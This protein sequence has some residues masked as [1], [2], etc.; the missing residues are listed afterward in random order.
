MF[1]GKF[2]SART[3]VV[4][5]LAALTFALAG[6]SAPAA[7][8][9]N[10]SLKGVF[11]YTHGR[12]GGASSVNLVVGQ[13]NLDGQG[14]VTSG[15][16]TWETNDGTVSFGITTGTYSVSKNCIGTLTLKDEDQSPS[17]SHFRIYLNASNNT[18]QI[19]QIDQNWNQPGFAVAQGT[20]TCGLSGKKQVFTTNLYG[21]AGGQPADTV[22]QVTLDGKG[23][24][25]GTE[26]F[27]NNG[28]VSNLAVTGSYTEITNCTG[29]WRI[30]P[31]NGTM[32]IFN[33]VVVNSGNELLLIQTDN[34]TFN[35]GSAQE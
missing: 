22:G 3:A 21:L 7:T 9:S 1:K 19:I 32:S 4:M 6:G 11:G 13:L 17:P 14:K 15:S 29:T 18:F 16:W 33:I 30:T 2:I 12:P 26:T 8:C 27:T 35:A 25:S 31:K 34:N 24:I 5:C 23:G 28:V 20:V 10:A